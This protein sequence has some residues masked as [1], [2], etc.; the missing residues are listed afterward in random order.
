VFPYLNFLRPMNGKRML[1]ME[2]ISEMK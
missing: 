2:L 1:E